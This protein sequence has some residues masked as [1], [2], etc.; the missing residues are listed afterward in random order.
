MDQGSSY[1]HFEN[2]YYYR[3]QKNLLNNCKM[4]TALNIKIIA[5]FIITNRFENKK[6]KFSSIINN[7]AKIYY[8]VKTGSLL[9]VNYLSCGW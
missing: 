2:S 1:E 5:M 6:A 9:D 8:K 4:L 7:Y 3:R